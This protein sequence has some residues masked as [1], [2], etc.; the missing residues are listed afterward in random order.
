M[1]QVIEEYKSAIKDA[2]AVKKAE[3]TKKMGIYAEA[4]SK[5]K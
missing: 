4:L 1:E 5:K 3:L 2:D